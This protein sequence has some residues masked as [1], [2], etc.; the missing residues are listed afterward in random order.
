MIS[1]HTAGHDPGA[2]GGEYQSM[3]GGGSLSLLHTSMMWLGLS[4]SLSP[5]S[6]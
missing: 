5:G 2:G 1:D 6:Y 4:R 3:T